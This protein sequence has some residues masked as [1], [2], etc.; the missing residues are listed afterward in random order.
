MQCTWNGRNTVRCIPWTEAYLGHAM[1]RSA[2]PHTLDR[3]QRFQRCKATGDWNCLSAGNTYSGNWG[4]S[5]HLLVKY[6]CCHNSVNGVDY[7]KHMTD[8]DVPQTVSADGGVSITTSMAAAPTYDC[9]WLRESVRAEASTLLQIGFVQSRTFLQGI[10]GEWGCEDLTMSCK[11]PWWLALTRVAH[12]PNPCQGPL[13]TTRIAKMD[14][15][16]L[17][18]KYHCNRPADAT[19]CWNVSG[20]VPN[21]ALCWSLWRLRLRADLCRVPEKHTG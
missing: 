18:P 5:G 6:N 1:L 20:Q 16:W 8:G 4:P 7:E 3:D 12:F 15:G 11:G 21:V 2:E 10:L 19:T 17:R 14:G 13:C 9:Q